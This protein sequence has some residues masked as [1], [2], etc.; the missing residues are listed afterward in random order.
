[1]YNSATAAV[2]YASSS[3]PV[4]RFGLG[5]AEYASA[6]EIRWPG[7]HVQNLGRVDADRVVNV[8]EDR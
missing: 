7:G 3:E 4:V 6:V 5:A 2:G 1:L 8:R